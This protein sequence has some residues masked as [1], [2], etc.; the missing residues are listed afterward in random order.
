MTI[1]RWLAFAAAI[2]LGDIVE[3]IYRRMGSHGRA[4]KPNGL[5]EFSGLRELRVWLA[6]FPSNQ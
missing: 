2:S 5:G 3:H 4:Y 6:R 1:E